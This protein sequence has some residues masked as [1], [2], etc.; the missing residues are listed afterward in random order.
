MDF[1]VIKLRIMSSLLIKGWM[2]EQGHE[3]NRKRGFVIILRNARMRMGGFLIRDEEEV[4]L[5]G[6]LLE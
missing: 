6:E 5:R 4:A 2:L 3:R 1:F